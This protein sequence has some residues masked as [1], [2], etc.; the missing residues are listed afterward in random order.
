MMTSILQAVQFPSPIPS[1][2]TVM[3]TR[4]ISKSKREEDANST[5]N[6]LIIVTVRRRKTAR[7]LPKMAKML[8]RIKAAILFPK[9]IKMSNR[10]MVA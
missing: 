3:S 1:P 10:T 8:N 2:N 7:L 5:D 6:L 9:M 4:S